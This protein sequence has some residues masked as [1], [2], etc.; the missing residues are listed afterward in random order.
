MMSVLWPKVAVFGCCLAP[1]ALVVGS[2]NSSASRLRETCQGALPFRSINLAQAIGSLHKPIR[3]EAPN[4]GN[5]QEWTTTLGG[6]AFSL[7]FSPS[8][9]T[10][11]V[12][13]AEGKVAVIDASSGKRLLSIPQ[14]CLPSSQPSSCSGVAYSPDGKWIAASSEGNV[15][16]LWGST[17]GERGLQLKVPWELPANSL[18]DLYSPSVMAFSPNGRVLAA[19]WQKKD[20]NVFVLH[21][22]CSG[23]LLRALPSLK[24][25]E[26]VMPA[27]G[28]WTAFSPDGVLL[29]TSYRSKQI[30]LWHI[31]TGKRIRQLVGHEGIVSG[32]SFSPDS[33]FLVSCAGY[34]GDRS[35]SELYTS[36]ATIKLWDVANGRCLFTSGQQRDNLRSVVF[37]PDGH[38]FAS[39]GEDQRIRLWEAATGKELRCWNV[40]EIVN[41]V[42]A[43]PDGASIAAA[44]DGG[45]VTQIAI[46]EAAPE[47][48]MAP[49]DQAVFDHLWAELG[50]DDVKAAFRGV[51]ELSA[52]NGGIVGRIGKR[53]HPIPHLDAAGLAGLIADLDADDF[54]RREAATKE[55]AAAGPKAEGT[56]R[57]TL[58]SNPSAEAR[59]RIERILPSLDQ[60]VVTD[61][62]ALRV[63]RAIWVLERIGTPEAREILEDLAK[64]APE[65]RQTQEAQAALDFLDKRAA[66]AVKP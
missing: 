65:V 66:A 30:T 13:G 29:A 19:R 18:D 9:A 8:G 59:S 57:K 26:S 33:R 47:S 23:M 51:R 50:S 41:Q 25:T 21:E 42:A 60:W 43:S 48:S 1:L 35:T 10:I 44:L 31:D 61:P 17:T 22:I 53:L 28:G 12:V 34:W 56:L 3:Y 6:S 54:D 64:G 58:E 32:V 40:G 14:R 11:A 39:G 37:L 27:T 36:E 62:D 5:D 55:L 24:A 20:D 7:A 49:M 2:A 63:L 52:A 16:Q 38:C 45:A 46:C 15:V 4:S